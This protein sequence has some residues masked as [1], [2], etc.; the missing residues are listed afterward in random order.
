MEIIN[1]IIKEFTNKAALQKKEIENLSENL[2]SL[3]EKI[4]HQII[5]LERNTND[6]NSNIQTLQY[7]NHEIIE[8]SKKEK[9]IT[10]KRTDRISYLRLDPFCGRG[11][12]KIMLILNLPTNIYKSS[13]N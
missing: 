9:V 11:R 5:K 7:L 3:I 8:Y 10:D 6:N 13:N 4:D 1:T 2:N 12:V